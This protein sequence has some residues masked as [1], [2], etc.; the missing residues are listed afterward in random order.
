MK[1]QIAWVLPAGFLVFVGLAALA[2]EPEPEA[3]G[4]VPDNW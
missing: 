3:E 1:R 4:T 2:A